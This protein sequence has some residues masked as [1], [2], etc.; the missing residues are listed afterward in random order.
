MGM[1]RL[2]GGSSGES[3]SRGVERWGGEGFLGG[4]RGFVRE[5]KDRTGELFGEGQSQEGV[6]ASN[7]SLSGSS[8]AGSPDSSS[9]SS[10]GSGTSNPSLSNRS[11]TPQQSSASVR[12]E[13][14]SG[15]SGSVLPPASDGS[16]DGYLQQIN[17]ELTTGQSRS[18]ID[19]AVDGLVEQ[20]Y[21][22][23]AT[24]PAIGS[25][26]TSAYAH[27]VSV[28]QSD[29]DTL[30]TR[31]VERNYYVGEDKAP[32][33]DGWQKRYVLQGVE[34]SDA[35]GKLIS[36][37]PGKEIALDQTGSG[38][39]I[40]TLAQAKARAEELL[41]HGAVTTDVGPLGNE[42]RERAAELEQTEAHLPKQMRIELG[43][44]KVIGPVSGW[45]GRTIERFTGKSIDPE[46]LSGHPHAFTRQAAQSL[47]VATS[48]D[49]HA[50]VIPN[51]YAGGQQYAS[52]LWKVN[53]EAPVLA[54]TLPSLDKS[55]FS[56]RFKE[57]LK[58]QNRV[59]W[60][61]HNRDALA[62]AAQEMVLNL[63]GAGAGKLLKAP[64]SSALS[65][66]NTQFSGGKAPGSPQSAFDDL[67]R[68]LAALDTT[69]PGSTA[70]R[71]VEQARAKQTLNEALARATEQFQQ[72]KSSLTPELRQRFV[73]LGTKA[74]QTLVNAGADS[75]A[76][77]PVSSH[78]KAGKINAPK[79]TASTQTSANT[80]KT[81][82]NVPMPKPGESNVDYLARTRIQQSSQDT[83]AL[84][85]AEQTKLGMQMEEGENDIVDATTEQHAAS[86]IYEPNRL[87]S[88]RLQ[89]DRS[90]LS[91]P[92]GAGANKSVYTYDDLA[93]A[94]SDH[95]GY[96]AHVSINAETKALQKLADA[97][98]PTVK[99]ALGEIGT[100][101]EPAVLMQKFAAN[102]RDYAALSCY[103]KQSIEDLELIKRELAEQKI[104]V[105]DLQFLVNRDGRLVVAD[106]FAI[107]KLNETKPF[108]SFDYADRLNNE[109]FARYH[110]SNLRQ[111]QGLIV[112]I[113]LELRRRSF[114][115]AKSD[116]THSNPVAGETGTRKELQEKVERGFFHLI[117]GE[118]NI[119]F[120]K[121]MGLDRTES[122]STLGAAENDDL[123]MQMGEE[124][125]AAKQ[126]K[127][128][129]R[130]ALA[131]ILSSPRRAEKLAR[132][133][134]TLLN[135]NFGD[136][137]PAE[138]TFL[139]VQGQRSVSERWKTD[140]KF[141][142]LHRKLFELAPF[143]TRNSKL[144]QFELNDLLRLG[145]NDSS[146]ILGIYESDEPGRG[147][148]SLWFTHEKL[149]TFG[150]D[151]EDANG[152]LFVH[153][154]Y[155]GL[156]RRGKAKTSSGLG[157]VFSLQG[158]AKLRNLGVDE[159][160]IV[161]GGTANGENGNRVW[162]QYGFDGP[163]PKDLREKLKAP[164]LLTCSKT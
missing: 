108:D 126:K 106:P 37:A 116:E 84:R 32:A 88:P 107:V 57:G 160:Q 33:T 162:P 128:F 68:A 145:P 150:L 21:D 52:L 31:I 100:H 148:L 11:S 79:S 75:N 4:L 147:Q 71:P 125:E 146:L 89:L 39:E 74:N 153:S 44:P 50:L 45:L 9:A 51:S 15:S 102:D 18:A 93:I 96:M 2:S 30:S 95:G 41:K 35:Q 99:F 123:K 101:K 12:R 26:K 140:E 91:K 20:S 38:A 5:V 120:M 69:R 10:V 24:P 137:A 97:G 131:D 94:L 109:K 59:E 118:S 29:G 16:V 8:T 62:N 157:T 3:E 86:P 76:N 46:Q 66:G 111:I 130:I 85:T 151:I 110:D 105:V 142:M 82:A 104:A 67:E 152:K 149:G 28:K 36:G 135:E 143:L 25:Y 64:N 155:V 92:I 124:A 13:Q 77:T 65:V 117:D 81:A 122:D 54:P 133:F 70:K 98:I 53:T 78:E 141:D 61:Q 34:K 73:S 27:G 138:K 49:N 6:P 114:A 134:N 43:A 14:G 121:R 144:G 1:F 132:R 154:S 63:V 156:D 139:L 90:K 159:I 48:K 127:T 163:L 80:P 7:S 164:K 72:N 22:A 129:E 23:V 119:D 161:A 103:S 58:D 113:K 158:T 47:G 87:L 19:Q 83:N 115:A 112:D 55:Q 40:T 56:V 136:G 42:P 17:Q 60:G